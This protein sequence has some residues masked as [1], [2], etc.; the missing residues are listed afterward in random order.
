MRK[1]FGLGLTGLMMSLALTGCSSGKSEKDKDGGKGGSGKKRIILLTNGDDPFWDTMRNGMNKA[2]ED[3]KLSEAGLTVALDKGD[4]SPGAQINKLNQYATQPDIAAVAISSVGA[5][6]NAIAQAMKDLRAK[7]VKVITV[8]SDMDHD[9]YRDTRFAYLGTDNIIGGQELGKTAKGLRSGGGNYVAFVGIKETAN[10]QQRTDGFQQGAGDAFKRLDYLGD[11][12]DRNKAQEN[13]KTALNNHSD[14][15]VLVGI[16][17]YNAH[18]IVQVVEQ[19]KLQDKIKVVVFDAAPQALADMEE[20]KIDA[21]VVQNPYQMGYEG[22]KLM[23]ALIEDDKKTIQELY[24]DYDPETGKFKSKDGDIRTTELRVVVPNEDS[25]L[26]PEMFDK[27]TKFFTYPK[28]KD[29]L[30][31]RKLEG[32]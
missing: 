19:R 5:D 31:A 10:A 23:K 22:T 17:A 7:G 24:P 13:V 9:K 14:I 28:F 32:S 18:A 21:M 29:W 11:G 26:K 27:D 16:W 15:N 4:G 12:M 25:P 2:A 20:G 8:D 30:S 3:L 1:W 6:N